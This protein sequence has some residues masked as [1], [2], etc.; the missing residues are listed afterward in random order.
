[1][2]LLDVKVEGYYQKTDLIVGS[3]EEVQRVQRFVA[4]EKVKKREKQTQEQQTLTETTST[5]STV[6][7]KKYRIK[8]K[9]AKEEDDGLDFLKTEFF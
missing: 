4:A 1:M 8:E 6:S 7:D 5:G 9:N 3:K 2:S